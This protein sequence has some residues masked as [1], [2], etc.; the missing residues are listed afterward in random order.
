MRKAIQDAKLPYTYVISYSADLDVKRSA[1]P[2]LPPIWEVS[3]LW[4]SRLMYATQS[5]AH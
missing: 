2:C 5:P 1:V 4:L 3:S